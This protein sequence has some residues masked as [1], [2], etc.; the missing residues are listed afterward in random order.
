VADLPSGAVTFVFTD[1]EGSTRLVRRLRGDYARVLAEHQRLL[2]AAF[3]THGGHEIDT[4]GDA[5]FYAF[6][7]AHEAVLA[8][9][10]GQRA[11]AGFPWPEDAEVKVRMGVHTGQAAP[12]NGRYTGLAVHRAARICAAGHGGQVLV[13][14]ATQSMIEDEEEDLAVKLQDLGEQRLKDIDRPVRLYQVAAAGLPA[15]FPSLRMEDESADTAAVA[16]PAYRRPFVFVAAAALLL[17]AAAVAVLLATRSEGDEAGQAAPAAALPDSLAVIDPDTNRI[18][19]NVR[20]AGRPSL[21]AADRRFVWVASDASRTVSSISTAQQA[22]TDVVAPNAAPSAL[23]A[24]GEAVWVFD[25]SRRVLL[26]IDATYGAVTRRIHLPRQQASPTSSQQSKSQSVYAGAGALW[27]TDGSSRLLR[28]DPDTEVLKALDV[29]EPL[30]DVAVGGGNVWAISG[31]GA[32]V[33]QI[34][35]KNRAVKTRVRVVNRIGTAAPFPIAVTVGEASVWVL[36]GNTQTV[37]RIDPEFAGVAA[38]IP[39]GIGRNSN[40]VA[41][42]AGGV[43]VANGGDG[44][45]TRI[46]PSTNTASTVAIG[47]SPTG[48]AVGGGRV[49]VTVQPGFRASARSPVAVSAG[50]RLQALPASNCSPVEFEGKGEPRFLIASDLP[51]QGEASLRETLQMSDAIRFI[52]ARRHFRAGPYSVG[53]QSCDDSLASTGIYDVGRCKA[54]ARAYARTRR[55]I[56]VIGSYNSSCTKALIAPLA[57]ARGGPVAMVSPAN[58]YVGLTHGGPGAAP[59]EPQKY[60]PRGVRN[61][62]RVVVADDLQG[63]A[64][65]ILAKQLKITRLFVLN[66]DDAY[67]IGIAENVRRAARKLGITVVG[68]ER[69]NPRVGPYTDLARKIKRARSDGIFLGGTSESANGASVVKDLRSA[70]GRRVPI[71]TPDGFTPFE[72][73]AQLAGPAAEGVT[74]SFPAVPPERLRG[75]GQRFVSEFGAAVGTNVEAYS[76]TTAQATQVLLDAIAKSDGSRASVTANLFKTRVSNGILGTFS[77]D[78]NGDTTAGAVTIYRI[79]DGKAEILRVITPPADLVK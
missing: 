8:A 44:T 30:N 17:A 72:P 26:R 12:V 36:N 67:G 69:W 79:V 10:E 29:G 38:T 75:E 37:T 6:A 39:L 4:Q 24:E 55:V 22:V 21:V 59:G 33:F 7:S 18:T 71:I 23:G 74:I 45:V 11:L 20:I 61:F 2:R 52:L 62:A 41:A 27:I 9:I 65:A 16:V 3:D 46:D 47:G 1:I 31:P 13:S 54:N 14:Q 5:F 66:D 56:G 77:F 50:A 68:F 78:R 63:A 15:S 42:G 48:I 19:A 53:Y 58:T 60:Y 34:D 25:G 40:D 51:F 32:S 76:V 70:L 57:A 64:N 35:T 28:I 43:W 49:W 73:F